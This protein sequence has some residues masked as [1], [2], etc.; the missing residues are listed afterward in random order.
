LASLLWDFFW[1]NLLCKKKLPAPKIAANATLPITIPTIPPALNPSSSL[2]E[3]LSHLDLSKKRHAESKKS[4]VAPLTGHTT[5]SPV[6]VG[7]VYPVLT[8]L[9]ARS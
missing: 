4:D 6:I 1:R 9:V 2:Y 3:E 5:V 7:T 8:V